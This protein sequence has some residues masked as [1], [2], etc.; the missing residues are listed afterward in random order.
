M[1]CY[2]HRF[3]REVVQPGFRY[4]QRKKFMFM[5]YTDQNVGHAWLNEYT[6]AIIST[7]TVILAQIRLSNIPWY[8]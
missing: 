5:G 8:L 4:S 3:P 6:S 7:Q 2:L 1:H